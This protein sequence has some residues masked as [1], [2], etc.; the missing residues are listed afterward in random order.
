MNLSEEAS[1]NFAVTEHQGLAG[2]FWRLT[3]EGHISA[4]K[5]W[6]TEPDEVEV[7]KATA[8]FCSHV[9][10]LESLGNVSSLFDRKGNLGGV[11]KNRGAESVYE[12]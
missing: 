6:F 3:I 5:V 4:I 1:M 2:P 12:F 7:Y 11:I 8:I 10:I 9:K